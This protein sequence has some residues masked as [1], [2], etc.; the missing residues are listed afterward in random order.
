[1]QWFVRV[2]GPSLFFHAVRPIKPK[3]NLKRL[4]SMHISGLQI[5][6]TKY[7][8]VGMLLGSEYP[9]FVHTYTVLSH[10]FMFNLFTFAHLFSTS[11]DT[12]AA[13][14]IGVEQRSGSKCLHV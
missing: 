2:L 7:S 10:Y 4:I 12:L 9:L 5:N 11:D 13:V 14:M 6:L 8:H 1:M 3:K